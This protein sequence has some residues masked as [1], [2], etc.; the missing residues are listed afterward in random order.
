MKSNWHQCTIFSHTR[1]VGLDQ[2]AQS[3]C[4]LNQDKVTRVVARHNLPGVPAVDVRGW[5][6]G[7]VTADDALEKI[8]A[9]GWKRRL[10]RRCH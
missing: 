10:P 4:T 9:T 7:M 5:M 6:R 2:T 1:Q 3:R 8:I